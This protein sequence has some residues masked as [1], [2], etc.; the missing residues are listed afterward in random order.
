MATIIKRIEYLKKLAVGIDLNVRSKISDE[1]E[2]MFSTDGGFHDLY[3][4]PRTEDLLVTLKVLEAALKDAKK[5]YKDAKKSLKDG[6]MSS[7]DLASY[8]RSVDDIINK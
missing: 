3:K 2:D 7:D 1:I 4:E 5:D 6:T 8:K